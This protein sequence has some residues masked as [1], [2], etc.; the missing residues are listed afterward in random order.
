MVY[1]YNHMKKLIAQEKKAPKNVPQ[2][3]ILL[4]GS[5]LPHDHPAWEGFE[6]ATKKVTA[7]GTAAVAAQVLKPLEKTIK[8]VFD[9]QGEPDDASEDVRLQIACL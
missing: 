2:I 1:T 8:D 4:A 6:V 3:Q 7:D 5:V 9:R